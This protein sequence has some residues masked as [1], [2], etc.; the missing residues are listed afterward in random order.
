MTTTIDR[1]HYTPTEARYK[2][3]AREMY[4]T[5]DLPQ[6]TRGEGTAVYPKVKRVYIA[7]DV[8]DWKLG[9]FAKR[10]G[11]K[12]RGV[13]IDY[14]Q[15]RSAYQRRGYVARRGATS[16]QVAPTRVGG[17][18]THFSTIVEV[19]QEARDVRFHEGQLP[20]R[21]RQALQ[22]VR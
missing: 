14:E 12:V 2:G 22:A 10:T 3:R 9:T 7:G 17:G 4:L 19:P 1:H 20:D 11:K 18:T 5:Y 15:S 16:Y 6:R 13:K 8:K 21:Y